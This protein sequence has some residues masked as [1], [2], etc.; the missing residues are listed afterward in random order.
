MPQLIGGYLLFVAL[1]KTA[2]YYLAA[3]LAVVALLDWAVRTRR[4]NPFNP[5]A[6][7]FRRAVDPLIAPVERAV[8]RAGGVPTSAPW[9]ALVAVVV[10]GI[11]LVTLL[12]MLGGMLA[13]IAYAS[14]AGAGA[15]FA[16]LGSLTF[17][18]LR[19]A[20]FV[21]VVASWIPSVSPYS[22]WVRWAFAVTEPFLAP[23]RRLL[24]TLGAIDISPLV[25]YFLLGIVER[26]VVG[27]L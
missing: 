7:F 20:L 8:V 12:D 9:W 27:A 25:A 11:I 14:Q 15:L 13:S 4:I 24:P 26:L 3:V 17:G 2:L 19:L 6:R 1:L 18:F 23:L 22:P 5:V 10:G 16:T 21:R